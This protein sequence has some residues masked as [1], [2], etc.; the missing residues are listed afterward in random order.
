MKRRLLTPLCNTGGRFPSDLQIPRN[1]N[2][3]V[4][5]SSGSS[6]ADR[7][8]VGTS[9]PVPDSAQAEYARTGQDPYRLDGVSAGTRPGTGYSGVD[10]SYFGQT[11]TVDQQRDLAA[12]PYSTTETAAQPDPSAEHSSLYREWMAPAATGVAGA[13]VGAAAVAAYSGQDRDEIPPPTREAKSEPFPEFDHTTTS[14]PETYIPTGAMVDSRSHPVDTTSASAANI[15][16][17]EEPTQQSVP[18]PVD[19][20]FAFATNNSVPEDQGDTHVTSTTPGLG[21]MEREGAQE[22]GTVFPKVVR[23][24]T[25]MS[26]SQLH[27]PGEYPKQT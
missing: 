26:V 23:H 9:S 8:D 18:H 24:D 13:G 22:T 7:E 20:T 4:G 19:N 2:I 10:A 25:E 27:I 15:S 5:E 12:D 6:A 11:S 14:R 17:T 3:S 1:R 16:A 21:G